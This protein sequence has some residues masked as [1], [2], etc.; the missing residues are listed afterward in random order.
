MSHFNTAFFYFSVFLGG[1]IQTL[2]MS[3]EILTVEMVK[4][5]TNAHGTAFSRA[6]VILPTPHSVCSLEATSDG[7]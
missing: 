4:V 2:L 1:Q 5:N 3:V 7:G 6:R